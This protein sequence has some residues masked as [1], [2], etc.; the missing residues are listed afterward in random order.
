M[1]RDEA[2][3]RRA[4]ADQDVRAEPRRLGVDLALDAERAAQRHRE[5]DSQHHHAVV[6][7]EQLRLH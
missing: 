4:Q 7:V 3:Q 2:E 6:E 1:D 5:Q